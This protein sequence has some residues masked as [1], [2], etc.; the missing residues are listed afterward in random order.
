VSTFFCN[1]ASNGFTIG[2]RAA[3]VETNVT[4]L[5]PTDVGRM[6]PRRDQ[7]KLPQAAILAGTLFEHFGIPAMIRDLG[8]DPTN[9]P[10]IVCNR[11]A[12][13]DYVAETMV[14][15]ALR[16]SRNINSYV[17]TAWFP[18]AVQGYLTIRYGNRGQAITLATQDEEM[19]AGTVE[20]LRDTSYSEIAIL[21]SFETVP[22]RIGQSIVSG[23]RPATF[24]AVTLVTAN[25][26]TKAILD[27]LS[28]HRAVAR[29]RIQAEAIMSA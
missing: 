4:R 3:A 11:Y 27:A 26:T 12:N 29:G 18:A 16:T 7:Q 25:H 6:V 9:T 10:L 24:G 8:G 14:P 19:I 1:S 13:W 5:S 28:E 22:A 2:V 15:D 17:A 23:D 21:S 20:A